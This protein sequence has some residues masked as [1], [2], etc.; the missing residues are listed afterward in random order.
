MRL[1]IV[2]IV[3]SLFFLYTN[4]IFAQINFSY[5]EV[6]KKLRLA[7]KIF[8]ADID[9]DGDLDVA[10]AS[11]SG[12]PTIAE[13]LNVSWYERNNNVFIQNYLDT[14]FPGARSIY[15]GD[16]D[17]SSSY[18]EIVAGNSVTNNVPYRP[19]LYKFNGYSWSYSFIG[20]YA[21]N[22]TYHLTGADI[23]RDG[24]LDLLATAQ[25]ESPIGW[26]VG[27]YK[28]DGSAN[29]VPNMIDHPFN[30]V[31][32]AEAGYIDTDNDMD[33]AAISFD[34][35]ENVNNVRW[36][37]NDGTPE[38]G[39]WVGTNIASNRYRPNGL[40]LVDLDG[41][42]DLDLAVA[43]YGSFSTNFT[44]GRISWWSNDGSGN[45]SFVTD[46][47]TNLQETRCVKGADMDGDGDMD[48][49]SAAS[50]GQNNTNGDVSWYENDGN[51]GFTK[52]TI[53]TLFDYAYWV[54]PIDFDGDGDTDIV[55]SAQGGTPRN[56][57][58]YI[59][60]WKSALDDD[61]LIAGGDQ[62]PA[63]FW[64]G[65]VVIDFSAGSSDSVTVFYNA[66]KTPDRALV[67]AGIDHI[68][69]KGY[70]T[71]TTRKTGY[72]ASIDFYYGNSNVP[73]WSA[74]N[75][76]SALVICLWD[77]SNN[78]WIIAGSSQDIDP[79]NNKITVYGISSEMRPFSKWTLGST[80]P[81][82][83][84]PIQLVSF[85][86]QIIA[87][88]IK[89][90]WRTASEIN[91]L[92]FEIWRASQTDSNFVMIAD[93]VSYEELKGTGNSNQDRYYSFIDRQL[94][95]GTTY[96]YKLIDVDI[97]NQKTVH[98]PLEVT[99]KP[100]VLV[101]GFLLEQN[102]PNP[103]NGYTRI[104][105]FLASLDGSLDNSA[106]LKIFNMLGEEVKE[107]TFKH[108]QPGRNE[109]LWD[110]TDDSGRSVASGQ[111]IYRLEF[112]G[113]SQSRRLILLR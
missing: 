51:Q 34:E 42:G 84:L 63:S 58:G 22:Y 49:V 2:V 40:D 104:P 43:E 36:E 108:L 68:A 86:S 102:Y 32:C 7:K 1:K 96:Y 8:V 82:N 35:G 67:G 111:Y 26:A 16:F 46:I 98:G 76:E 69:F 39:G 80:T 41:D 106:T 27:W 64:N 10:A 53:T 56:Y 109:I 88:G 28:N 17:E 57:R 103:F 30:L 71:I 97:N 20:N 25:I 77:E 91:N 89:L 24:D 95:S 72:T 45:F 92:G 105:L 19:R 3:F 73:E 6:V 48:L 99:F 13:T 75:D 29:F 52:R 38:D 81:D 9:R 14:N 21:T 66:G 44:N 33:V 100:I 60:W 59:S 61:Q 94:I 83:S 79:V 65:K 50:M 4:D 85:S 112:S 93:W 54:I 101:S 78:E 90:N 70:Y 15:A 31:T 12:N 23:N 11:G 37:A 113:N 47:Y 110:G 5:R 18:L 55:G 74:I 87:D 62:D 107:L